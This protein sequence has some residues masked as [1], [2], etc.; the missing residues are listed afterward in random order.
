[1]SSE[2]PFDWGDEPEP[3]EEELAAAAKLRDELAGDAFAEALRAAHSPRDLAPERHEAIVEQ[4]LDRFSKRRRSNVVRVVFGGVVAFAAAAAAVLV[5][6]PMPPPDM[7]SYVRSRSTQD[8]FAE[9]F[10]AQ[11][12]TSARVDRIGDARARD[13][14]E[15]RFASWGVR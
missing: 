12:G 4:A 11:G 2:Q 3:T 7:P 9:P 15:N 5:Y 8:L 6:G 1:M 14:R 13:L 10:P